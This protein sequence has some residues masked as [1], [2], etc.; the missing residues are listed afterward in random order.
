MS[1][2]RIDGRTSDIYLYKSV[3]G[4]YSLT[5]PE[6]SKDIP[7]LEDVLAE[8]NRLKKKGYKIPK[9]AIDR[10]KLELQTPESSVN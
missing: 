3:Y 9:E 6:G 5:S 4:K 10:V 1:Y 8:L 2:A 7:R